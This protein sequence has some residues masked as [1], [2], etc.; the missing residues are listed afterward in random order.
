MKIGRF[1][2]QPFFLVDLPKI[3]KHHSLP[4]IKYTNEGLGRFKY[5]YIYSFS[6]KYMHV[7][8]L[9]IYQFKYINI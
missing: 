2:R 4:K 6:I 1:G 9:F 3:S 8:S 7:N 5:I